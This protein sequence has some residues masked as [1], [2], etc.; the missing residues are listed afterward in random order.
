[1]KNNKIQIRIS[2]E[3]KK[4]LEA[5]AKRAKLSLSKY[6]IEA[7][8]NNV[9]IYE[10]GKILAEVAY[11]INLKLEECKRCKDLPVYEIKQILSEKIKNFKYEEM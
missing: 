9:Y 4:E 10:G 6:L 11:D 8:K 2:D 7:G 1:M 5:K 3:E